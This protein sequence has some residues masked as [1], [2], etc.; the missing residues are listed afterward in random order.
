MYMVRGVRKIY[1][2]LVQFREEDNSSRVNW[3]THYWL[4]RNYGKKLK[5]KIRF[6]LFTEIFSNL[7][8]QSHMIIIKSY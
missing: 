5:D 2:I 8:V 4:P 3:K 6:N 1:K 7:T